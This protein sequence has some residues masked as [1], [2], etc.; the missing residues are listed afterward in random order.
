MPTVLAASSTLMPLHTVVVLPGVASESVSH[1][2]GTPGFVLILEPPGT[3]G[4]KN[5]AVVFLP[6]FDT[7]FKRIGHFSNFPFLYL[8]GLAAFFQLSLLPFFK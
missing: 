5:A 3:T 1:A 4:R 8:C 6:I 7:A 2:A